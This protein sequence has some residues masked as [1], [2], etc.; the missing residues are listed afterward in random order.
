MI[1][2]TKKGSA[3]SAPYAPASGVLEG[4]RRDAPADQVTLAWIMDHLKSRSF[5]IVIL[6]LGI[7]AI[8]PGV[9]PAVRHCSLHLGLPVGAG[10][11]F[12][13]SPSQDHRTT[14]LNPQACRLTP[15]RH[16]AASVYGAFH[17]TALAAAVSHA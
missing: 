12:S 7:C 8:I 1:Q 15:Q 5:G 9:S 2:R 17:P 14:D 16:L 3:P 4:L 13:C 10:Q 11:S 6:L